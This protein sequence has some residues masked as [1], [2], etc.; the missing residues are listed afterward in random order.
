MDILGANRGC[1]NN[2]CVKSDLGIA[3]F[4]SKWKGCPKKYLQSYRQVEHKFP[5][6]S[7]S[8]RLVHRSSGYRARRP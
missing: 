7:P 5:N 2:W 4:S 6:S 3:E 8:L 1:A